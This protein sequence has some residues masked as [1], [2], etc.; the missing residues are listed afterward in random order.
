MI[1]SLTKLFILVLL[2]IGLKRWDPFESSGKIL[3]MN[4]LE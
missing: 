1:Q 4:F 3:Q 2:P